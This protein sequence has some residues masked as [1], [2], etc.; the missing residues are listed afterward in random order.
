MMLLMVLLTSS[1]N[2]HLI[3]SP[4]P[5]ALAPGCM[6]LRRGSQLQLYGQR[7]VGDTSS[8]DSLS[9]T[10]IHMHRVGDR[11]NVQLYVHLKIFG[12]LER[13][14]HCTLYPMDRQW[15]MCRTGSDS[16]GHPIRTTPL[17]HDWHHYY[18]LVS[19]H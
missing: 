6:A 5:A 1:Q 3:G 13:M 11:N 9:S 2:E 4:F 14:G 18:M 17:H 10:N 16:M 12:L 8:I 7:W 19:P 15:E